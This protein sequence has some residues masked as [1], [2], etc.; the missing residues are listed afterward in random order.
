ME[1]VSKIANI[2]KSYDSYILLKDKVNS[3]NSY[4]LDIRMQRATQRLR[5]TN[6]IIADIAAKTGFPDIYYFSRA[7]KREMNVSPSEYREQYRK[8]GN[9]HRIGVPI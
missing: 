1:D 9:E 7:F 8:E 5:Y 6:T 4:I 2:R 3:I